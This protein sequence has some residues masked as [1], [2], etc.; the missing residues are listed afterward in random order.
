MEIEP[1]NKKMI[2]EIKLNYYIRVR[3]SNK[4]TPANIKLNLSKLLIG[5][6]YE[7]SIYS[8]NL[9]KQDGKYLYN[10]LIKTN[11][12]GVT[13]NLYKNISGKGEIELVNNKILLR[14]EK[15]GT[16]K[17]NKTHECVE[18][19]RIVAG[20]NFIGKKMDISVVPIPNKETSIYYVTKYATD[21][22]TNHTGFVTPLI[23]G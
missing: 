17:G 9:D 15:P 20:E 11:E 6:D 13:M 23:F 21:T 3:T 7:Y 12:H 1:I 19:F 10:L 22:T 5:I 8:L 16:K 4:V 14:V 2:G 18:E